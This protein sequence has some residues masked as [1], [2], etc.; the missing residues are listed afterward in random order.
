[1]ALKAFVLG[2]MLWLSREYLSGAMT[3]HTGSDLGNTLMI[4][5]CRD[6]GIFFPGNSI[7]ETDYGKDEYEKDDVVFHGSLYQKTG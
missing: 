5:V 1:M 7:E 6:L 4:V 3:F 2:R